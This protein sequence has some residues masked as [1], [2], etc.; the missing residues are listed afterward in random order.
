MQQEEKQYQ[1]RSLSESQLSGLLDFCLYLIAP[2]G[3]LLSS[4]Y[5]S[6]SGL[7]FSKGI[8][9][10]SYLLMGK[11]YTCMVPAASVGLP[12]ARM[13]NIV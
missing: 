3:I 1:E 9:Y 10:L 6:S 11:H 12:P 4:S 2:L 13:H 7:R 5:T 8:F